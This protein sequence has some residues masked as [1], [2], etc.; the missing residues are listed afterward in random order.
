MKDDSKNESG[1]SQQQYYKTDQS[2][3]EA[4]SIKANS[5]IDQII[6]DIE[7]QGKINNNVIESNT[8]AV[9]KGQIIEDQSKSSEGKDLVN[10]WEQFSQAIKTS[11]GKVNTG[12]ATGF[13]T[14]ETSQ[15][16][17]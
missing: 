3:D 10:E 17:V 8:K 15:R 11:K 9:P 7:L 4:E 6:W 13:Q 2:E 14:P 5:E 16:I 12:Q 1:Q